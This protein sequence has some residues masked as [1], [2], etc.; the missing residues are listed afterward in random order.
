MKCNLDLFKYEADIIENHHSILNDFLYMS[1]I[2]TPTII[3]IIIF[4]S[5]DHH[6]LRKKRNKGLVCF[7]CIHIA[8]DFLNFYLHVLSFHE[9]YDTPTCPE[10][11]NLQHLCI[12]QNACTVILQTDRICNG[13]AMGLDGYCNA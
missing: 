6:R 10:F 2:H 7:T 11:K 5:I 12:C 8:A 3:I 13:L 9:S 1:K 4:Y